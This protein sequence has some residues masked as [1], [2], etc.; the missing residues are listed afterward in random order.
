[1]YGILI[2]FSVCTIFSIL[3]KNIYIKQL[4]T[5]IYHSRLLQLKNSLKTQH[6]KLKN[7]ILFY[8]ILLKT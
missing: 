7:E 8:I 4:Y 2:I 1:M 5:I 6:I 3:E